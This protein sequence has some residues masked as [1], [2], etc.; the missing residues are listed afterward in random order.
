MKEEGSWRGTQSEVSWFLSLLLLSFV[1]YLCSDSDK[2]MDIKT[3]ELSFKN[4]RDLVWFPLSFLMRCS[5]LKDMGTTTMLQTRISEGREHGLHRANDM[6]GCLDYAR[7]VDCG[8]YS[9][10]SYHVSLR[11]IPFQWLTPFSVDRTRAQV[12]E[13]NA[14]S[15]TL[16]WARIQR[17][18]DYWVHS[19]WGAIVNW[20]CQQS[21]RFLDNDGRDIGVSKLVGM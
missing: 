11:S 7:Y 21:R 19:T 17:T 18:H 4:V 14:I 12:R 16:D 6:A 3:E 8:H 1:T 2:A 15:F 10:L 9:S 13:C 5:R 20:S